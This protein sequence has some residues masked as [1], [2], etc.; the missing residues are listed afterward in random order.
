LVG[1]SG[2][3]APLLFNFSSAPVAVTALAVVTSFT[4]NNNNGKPQEM[5]A[6]KRALHWGHWFANLRSVLLWSG[7]TVGT[8]AGSN[9][10]VL[11][12]VQVEEEREVPG[13]SPGTSESLRA[14]LGARGRRGHLDVRTAQRH[15]VGPIQDM[16][17]VPPGQASCVMPEEARG[18]TTVRTRGPTMA[19]T[20]CAPEHNAVA[21][22][23]LVRSVPLLLLLCCSF[24]QFCALH[25]SKM[26]T[27]FCSIA[28]GS[29]P[30]AARLERVR[31]VGNKTA[32]PQYRSQTT[33]HSTIDGAVIPDHSSPC[34]SVRGAVLKAGRVRRTALLR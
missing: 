24:R 11:V 15:D 14:P 18:L 34:F 20:Q 12:M 1:V 9:A 16:D 32:S 10:C 33:I 25:A 29:S 19:S 31:A 4:S 22:C 3:Y 30:E 17:S 21:G 27:S 2:M 5:V 23:S 28:V 26:R 7:T 13:R 6:P 8:G